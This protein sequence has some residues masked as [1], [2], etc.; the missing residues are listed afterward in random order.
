MLCDSL[1]DTETQNELLAEI[2]KSAS[3]HPSVLFNVI[4]NLNI[5]PRWEDMPLPKGQS[6]PTNAA[7]LSCCNAI[8][9]TTQGPLD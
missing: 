4:A 6:P 5:H 3:P 8:R 1:A 2:I 7:F 9:T